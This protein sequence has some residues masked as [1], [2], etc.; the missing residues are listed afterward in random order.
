MDTIS[1]IGHKMIT[2]NNSFI[3]NMCS[4][5]NLLENMGVSILIV[6]YSKS[7]ARY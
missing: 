4:N 3:N 5:F 1:N 2:E 6:Y 7:A